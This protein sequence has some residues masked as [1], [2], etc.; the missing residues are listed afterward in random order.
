MISPLPLNFHANHNQSPNRKN[1]TEQMKVKGKH[2]LIEW[3]CSRDGVGA[4]FF[5][6]PL[7]ISFYVVTFVF[8]LFVNRDARL[9]VT[10]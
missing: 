6:F 9:V 10:R 4:R 3:P 2:D 7:C 1:L 5:F 8:C